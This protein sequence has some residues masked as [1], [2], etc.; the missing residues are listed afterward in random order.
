MVTTAAPHVV[1]RWPTSA[2]GLQ[3]SHEQGGEVANAISNDFTLPENFRASLLRSVSRF[4][5]FH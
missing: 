2:K 1:W 3:A 5:R 4:L